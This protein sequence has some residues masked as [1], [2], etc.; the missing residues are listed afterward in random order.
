MIERSFRKYAGAGNDFVVLDAFHEALPLDG[1]A[2]RS[3]VTKACS[4]AGKGIGSDGL[5]LLEP[6]V[7]APFQMRFFNPDGSYGALCGNGARCAVQAAKDHQIVSDSETTFEVLGEVDS[8]ELLAD[9][10]VRVHIQDPKRMKLDF[11]LRIGKKDFV[12]T[13]YVDLGSQHA[14]TFMQ[15]L[16]PFTNE[17]IE[18]FAINRFG[19]LIRWQPDLQPEGVNANFAEIRTD[20]EGAYVRI[21]TFERGVEGET[22]ACGTGCMSTAIVTYGLGKIRQLPIR[23]LTQSGEFVKVNFTIEDTQ[24]HNLTIEGSAVRGKSGTLKFDVDR[25]T[26]QVDWV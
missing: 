17:T 20:D 26:L 16:T 9:Q 24:V 21:R 19:P 13:S 14:V 18:T 1:S 10:L 22:L 11:K 25:D 5:I 6:S 23:L 8:A 2:L 3:F 15:D 7:K 12:T 4:R